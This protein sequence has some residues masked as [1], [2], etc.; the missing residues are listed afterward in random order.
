M[1]LLQDACQALGAEADGCA[2]ISDAD[3]ATGVHVPPP[4]Q[5][6]MAGCQR[7]TVIRAEGGTPDYVCV[8]LEHT[9]DASCIHVPQTGSSVV[10][11]GKA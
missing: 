2:F 9:N 10:R 1:L 3:K 7:P 11:A 5:P 8:S 6:V 4:H